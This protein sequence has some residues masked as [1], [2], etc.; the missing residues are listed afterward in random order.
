M[1]NSYKFVLFIFTFIVFLTGCKVNNP[2]KYYTK[3]SLVKKAM[4]FYK[5]KPDGS[6]CDDDRRW[7]EK[8]NACIREER[9]E[10]QYYYYDLEWLRYYKLPSYN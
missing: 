10:K 7:I 3:Q 8:N 2:E 4:E 5:L 9:A 6:A 1:P